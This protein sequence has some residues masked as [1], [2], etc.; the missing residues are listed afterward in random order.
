MAGVSQYGAPP[1]DPKDKRKGP[2][3]GDLR[4]DAEPEPKKPD[5]SPPADV[6]QQFHKN[7]DLD[8]SATSQ[9]HTLGTAEYNA[10]SGAHNHRDGLSV[11]LFDGLVLTGS[12]G[13]NV[14]LAN[15]ISLLTQFGLTD[16]TS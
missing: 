14:A 3:Y 16:N 9:H 8:R 13:G 5:P 11:P 6:V 1:E 4:R 2:G 7:S 10:A 15:L 12:K